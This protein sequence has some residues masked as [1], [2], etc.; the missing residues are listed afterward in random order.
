MV[1]FP[2]PWRLRL[3]SGFGPQFSHVIPSSHAHLTFSSLSYARA[4]HVLNIADLQE[5]LDNM[6]KDVECR[7]TQ[8]WCD[9]IAKHKK[10]TN[11]STPSFAICDF[12]LV[13]LTTDRDYKI[14]FCW[15]GLCW[16]T[17]E[18][19]CAGVRC[20]IASARQDRT[21]S[22]CSAHSLS[23]YPPRY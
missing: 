18:Y 12:V 13:H 15:P 22:L 5:A 1:L 7:V 21:S 4:R 23:W 20:F 3:E 17:A 14:R 8:I 10:A 16:I 6:Y 9:E 11:L 19:G 2:C